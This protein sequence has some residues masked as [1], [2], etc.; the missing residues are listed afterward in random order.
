MEELKKYGDTTK[1]HWLQCDLKDL[2]KTDETAK[3]LK[4]EQQQI[5]ALICNA[6]QGV[7]KYN[8]TGDGMGMDLFNDASHILAGTD[9]QSWV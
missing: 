9:V 8:E 2:R 5:D 6:G 4:T 7:G 1:V 3:R